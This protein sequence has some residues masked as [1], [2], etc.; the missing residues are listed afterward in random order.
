M[1]S[2]N[3]SQIKKY[4]DWIWICT[5]CQENNFQNRYKCRKCGNNKED[6]TFLGHIYNAKIKIND[7]YIIIESKLDY[8]DNNY[9]FPIDEK[10]VDYV[11]EEISKYPNHKIKVDHFMIHIDNNLPV[12]KLL[13]SK[14][15]DRI[16]FTRC[17]LVGNH[18]G[19]YF[20]KR[21]KYIKEFIKQD[22]E[23]KV[24]NN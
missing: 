14:L 9:Y 11:C 2:R 8:K 15:Q 6:V 3:C 12:V 1:D 7:E 22:Y 23:W 19:G 5:S 13:I 20:S 24:H 18:D 16:I 4:D 21:P 17:S 10:K